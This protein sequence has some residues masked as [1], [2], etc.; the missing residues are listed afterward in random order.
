[1]SSIFFEKSRAPEVHGPS[2]GRCYRCRWREVDG[3]HT[4]RYALEHNDTVLGTMKH[5]GLKAGA[6]CPCFKRDAE[7]PVARGTIL[8]AI[9]EDVRL[10]KATP[11]QQEKARR[12]RAA[13]ERREKKEAERMNLYLAGY[14]DGAIAGALGCTK[15]TIT[16][17]RQ[18][19]NL[20]ANYTKKE[21]ERKEREKLRLR[22]YREGCSDSVIA[23]A[24]SCTTSTI[25]LWRQSR[26]LPAN[27]EPGSGRRVIHEE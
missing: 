2:R 25:T 17:W 10:A 14:S 6:P 26:A 21:K 8:T 18:K 1:M 9:G 5:L 13:V 24:L 15:S 19:N 4:C 23:K 3:I 11:Q 7:V 12:H 20:T 16:T 22:L 27:Y